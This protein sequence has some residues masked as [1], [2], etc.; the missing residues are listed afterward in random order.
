MKKDSDKMDFDDREASQSIFYK[1]GVYE[2]G[3]HPCLRCK[4]LI[5]RVENEKGELGKCTA[6]PDGIPF[7]TYVYMHHW[8]KPEN[9]NNGIGFEPIDDI[10][11]L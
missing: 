2:M 3:L 11:R 7:E 5:E 6:F 4:N 8:D 10:Y 1:K 9:C